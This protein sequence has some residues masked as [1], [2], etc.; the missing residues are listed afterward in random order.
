MKCMN[1]SATTHSGEATRRGLCASCYDVQ[2]RMVGRSETTWAK[3]EAASLCGPARRRGPTSDRR[4]R[5]EDALR[6]R[7]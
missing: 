7:T 5:I 6:R 3:L 4:A 2:R 1:R